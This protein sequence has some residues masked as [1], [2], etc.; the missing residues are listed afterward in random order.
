MT[1]PEARPNVHIALDI[2]QTLAGGVVSAHM[3]HYNERLGLGIAAETIEVLDSQ[4]AKTFDVPEIADYRKKDEDGFQKVRAEIRTSEQVH[5]DFKTLPG[6]IDGALAL[7]EHASLSYYSVRPA[8]V[9][10]ATREWLRK[11]GFPNPEDVVICDSHEDK[12][13][14][15]AVDHL[16]DNPE[17]TIV[18]IDDSHKQLAEAAEAIVAQEPDMKIQFER[19]LLVGFGAKFE[20]AFYPNSGLRTMSL[21]S[22]EREHLEQ[23]TNALQ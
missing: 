6:S 4:Y 12:L 23:V 15:I 18:L 11:H 14:R 13:R 21:P 3:R 8:E 2:D 19:L 17:K 16:A 7:L 9:E 20:G 1:T 10:G 22:W 5:L